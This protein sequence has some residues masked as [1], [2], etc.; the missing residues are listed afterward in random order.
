MTV[1]PD[2]WTRGENLFSTHSPRLSWLII[3]PT[4]FVVVLELA[5]CLHVERCTILASL[6]VS[7]WPDMVRSHGQDLEV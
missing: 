4:P 3:A 5:P 7:W 1:S 2:L 6:A